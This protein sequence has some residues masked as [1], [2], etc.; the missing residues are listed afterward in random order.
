MFALH[1]V[2]PIRKA[3]LEV[4]ELGVQFASIV[5][6]NDSSPPPRH[7]V[8]RVDGQQRKSTVP[9][10]IALETLDSDTD[11]DNGESRVPQIPKSSRQQ[12]P[13]TTLRKI[14]SDFTRLLHFV[15]AGLRSV[16]RVGAEPMWE[17]LAERLEW[18]GKKDAT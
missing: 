3:I 16:G 18:E 17:Q 10:P 9:A 13:L 14:D 8:K 5:S 12:T 6:S 11:T 4:L 2:K 15:T 7:E 1:D